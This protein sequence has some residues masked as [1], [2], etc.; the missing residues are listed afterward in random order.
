MLNTQFNIK[1]QKVL[2]S[3]INLH[4]DVTIGEEALLRKLTSVIIPVG[5][6]SSGILPLIFIPSPLFFSLK[7]QKPYSYYFYIGKS[8]LVSAI[9]GAPIAFSQAGT[10]TRRPVNYLRLPHNSSEG[11]LPHSPSLF[12]ILFF[13]YFTSFFLL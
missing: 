8:R 2:C 10:A 1:T 5:S 3:I 7:Y 12:S 11:M 9:L 4:A 6:Q 13:F